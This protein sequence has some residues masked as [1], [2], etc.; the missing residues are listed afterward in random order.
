MADISVTAANV[1]KS[2]SGK[3]KTGVSAVAILAGQAVYKLAAGTIGLHDANGVAPQNVLEGIAENSAPGVGQPITYC[4]DDPLFDP[5]ATVA[6]GAT[7][8]GSATPGGIAPDADKVTGWTVN[9][10]AHGVG[11]NKIAVKII[12]TG[13]VVP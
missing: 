2:V 10:L 4:Y 9:E 8:I 12:N 11:S 6:A 1:K 13:A 3:S 5:G 7:L